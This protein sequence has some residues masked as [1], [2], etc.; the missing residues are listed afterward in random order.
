MPHWGGGGDGT[1]GKRGREG[2]GGGRG[3]L[4][5]RR[6]GSSIQGR[7]GQNLLATLPAP[8]PAG[9]VRAGADRRLRAG[10]ALCPLPPHSRRASA[11]TCPRESGWREGGGELWRPSARAAR[12][13]ALVA[14]PRPGAPPP[15]EPLDSAT[16]RRSLRPSQP[17]RAAVRW[18]Q[19]R[20]C[21]SWVRFC[22]TASV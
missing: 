12:S 16:P 8:A 17:L 20:A 7:R 2:T 3:P 22:K 13:R 4:G 15:T 21:L 11:L 18:W 10:V 14:P 19:R 5:Q 1:C 6:T 9:Q